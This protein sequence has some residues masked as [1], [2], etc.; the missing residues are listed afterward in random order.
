MTLRDFLVSCIRTAVPAGVGLV[1][2]HFGINA[3]DIAGVPL[4]TVVTAVAIMAYYS[5][6]RALEAKWPKV[7]ILLG[8]TVA[9]SYAAPPSSRPAAPLYDGSNSAA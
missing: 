4:Q 2:A 6:V 8:W 9:P 1:L 3:L 5:G 7:G